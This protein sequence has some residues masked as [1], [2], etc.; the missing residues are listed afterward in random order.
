MWIKEFVS[1]ALLHS[2]ADV[3]CLSL[4]LHC[5]S[6]ADSL[7]ELSADSPQAAGGLL[8]LS[9]SRSA[10]PSAPFPPHDFTLKL[11]APVLLLSPQSAPSRMFAFSFLPAA[12]FLEKPD[13][14]A[15]RRGRGVC[16]CRA[17]C[18]TTC[19]VVF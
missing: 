11:C 13:R 16:L 6:C 2:E 18:L 5:S 17:V 8:C 19:C 4:K 14:A 7:L 9:S 12:A 15:H 3:S 10:S 1:F